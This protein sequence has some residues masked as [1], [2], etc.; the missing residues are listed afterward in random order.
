ME[1]KDKVIDK[2]DV[3]IKILSNKTSSKFHKS[4]LPQKNLLSTLND[5]RNKFAVTPVDKD[6]ENIAIVGQRFYALVLI[7]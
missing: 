5:I 6:N 1:W 3:K 4:V 2:L 7:K